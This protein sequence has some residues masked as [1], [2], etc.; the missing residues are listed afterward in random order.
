M[1]RFEESLLEKYDSASHE[2]R[3]RVRLFFRFTLVLIPFLLAYIIFLNVTLA[4]DFFSAV[5]VAIMVF[6][7]I[8]FSAH[9]HRKHFPCIVRLIGIKSPPPRTRA[10]VLHLRQGRLHC[11][12]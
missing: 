9:L 10:A 8:V 2:V 3:G 5:N 11:M 1:K 12:H 4:R 7:V 6:I